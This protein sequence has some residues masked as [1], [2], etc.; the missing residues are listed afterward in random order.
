MQTQPQLFPQALTVEWLI[1][2]SG[3]Y[4]RAARSLATQIENSDLEDVEMCRTLNDRI[5]TVRPSSICIFH[6]TSKSD[7]VQVLCR[8]VCLF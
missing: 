4:G 5:M 8:V 3:S 6:I 2:A 7:T 1:W